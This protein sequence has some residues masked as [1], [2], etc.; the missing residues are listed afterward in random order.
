MG[1]QPETVHLVGAPGLDNLAFLRLL[2]RAETEDALGMA[3]GDP[4]FVVTVGLGAVVTRP[5]PSGLTPALQCMAC[6]LAAPR[7]FLLL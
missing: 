5:V 4:T 3:F 7:P 2:G 1:E 6:R